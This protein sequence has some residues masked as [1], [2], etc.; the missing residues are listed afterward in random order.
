MMSAIQGKLHTSQQGVGLVE[1]LVSL[2]LLAVTAL[3]YSA[4]QAR[5][6]ASTDEAMVRTQAQIIL[7]NAAE[8]IRINS[9][10]ADVLSAYQTHLTAATA[11]STVTCSK[12]AKCTPEIVAK[13]DV[14]ML[15]E[16]ASAEG[17]KLGMVTCP[18]T[19]ATT[20]AQTKCLVAAWN[21]THP[22]VIATGSAVTNA[23]FKED[24]NYLSDADC[25]YMEAY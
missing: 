16:Q 23:C 1:V 21:D 24:G 25:V 12:A 22:I 5:S 7:S 10:S 2:L 15:R 18:G 9:I 8:R 19:T 13:N 3:G 6:I 11:P 20:A 17:I 4:L 14:A